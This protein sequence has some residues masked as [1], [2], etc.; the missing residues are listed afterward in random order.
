MQNVMT[1]RTELIFHNIFFFKKQILVP[2]KVVKPT[3]LST[4]AIKL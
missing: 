1:E 4:M 3:A 2:K